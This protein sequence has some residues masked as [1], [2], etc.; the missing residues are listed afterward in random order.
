[1]SEKEFEI[2]KIVDINR[3]LQNP[4]A[5]RHL[6]EVQVPPSKIKTWKVRYNYILGTLMV[7]DLILDLESENMLEIHPFPE[8]V[9][10]LK[11]FNQPTTV[12]YL[13]VPD[14]DLSITRKITRKPY[15]DKIELI[16]DLISHL[17]ISNLIAFEYQLG[18]NVLVPAFIPHFFISS[19]FDKE[20]H[21]AAPYLQVFE[22]NIN[23]LQQTL[24]I[25][26][27]SYFQLPFSVFI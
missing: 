14:L 6:F 10:H 22:P 18:V 15:P 4:A 7:G 25:K 9:V 8:W 26:P 2:Q 23:A 16:E 24:N 20:G 13:V 5:Y 12:P 19:K 11:R 17:T 1:M 27:T 3:Y 21:V